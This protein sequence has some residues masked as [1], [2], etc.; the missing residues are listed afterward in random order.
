MTLQKPTQVEIDLYT[1]DFDKKIKEIDE[2][3]SNYENTEWT[4]KFV[5]VVF[6]IC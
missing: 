6:I 3:I 1:D 5:P 2:L 4:T